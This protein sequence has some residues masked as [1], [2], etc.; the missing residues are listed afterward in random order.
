MPCPSQFTAPVPPDLLR[1]ESRKTGHA[2]AAACPADAATL[3][4]AVREAHDRGLTLTLQGSRTGISGGAVPEGGA[5][6]SLARM[7][8]VL[9][10]RPDPAT[11]RPLLRVQPG[12]TLAALRRHIAAEHPAFFFPPDPTEP[13]ASLGGM[14]ACNASGACSFAYGPVRPHVHALS[15]VLADGDTLALTRGA[16]RADGAR[17]SL[18]TGSG[19]RIEGTLPDL[20]QPRVKSAAGYFA[21]PGMD[22]LDLFIGSEGTLGLIAEIELRL[23]PKP[24]KTL[25][26]LCYF[27]EESPALAFVAALRSAAPGLRPHTLAAI[28]YFDTGALELIRASTPATGLLLPPPRPHWR[29]AVYLEWHLASDDPAPADLTLRLLEAHGASPADTWLADAPPA[30]EKLKAFRHAVPEQVNAL[31]AARKRRH[32][33]LTKLGTDLSVPDDRLADIMRLYRRDLAAAGLEHVIFG[34]IGDNHLHVNILP[35]DMAEHA[36]GK[37]LYRDWAAQAVAWGGSV[38]A[39]HGIGRLKKDLL[40]LMCGPGGIDAMRRLKTLFDPA[41]RLNPGRLFDNDNLP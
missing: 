14:T 18:A 12:L 8:A 4:A 3:A 33:D 28:E 41:A 32:P 7:D 6:L 39:E 16:D 31:I 20:P 21:R 29:L 15:V 34:H 5:V 11:G 13:S 22:L 24:R 37:R 25:G 27:P 40:A 9:G 19:R 10:A 17:F 36:L 2:E 1:D 23:S 35:R 26:V 30:L 38:S